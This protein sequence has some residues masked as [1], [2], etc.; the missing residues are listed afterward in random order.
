MPD[1]WT[2]ID[3][4]SKVG[5]SSFWSQLDLPAAIYF[6][7]VTSITD[8]AIGGRVSEQKAV[9]AEGANVPSTFVSGHQ[10]RTGD[11]RLSEKGIVGVGVTFALM[12]ATCTSNFVTSNETQTMLSLS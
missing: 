5:K 11:K 3:K 8:G 4:K 10:V 12:S 1:R 2:P 9:G 6:Y 7:T